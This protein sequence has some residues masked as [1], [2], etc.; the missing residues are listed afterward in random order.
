M[1]SYGLSSVISQGNQS[2]ENILSLNR[3]IRDANNELLSKHREKIAETKEDVDQFNTAEGRTL[4]EA[5]LGQ[6]ASKG[7]DI[8]AVPKVLKALP[9]VASRTMNLTDKYVIGGLNTAV[10]GV[11]RQV[12]RLFGDTAMGESNLGDFLKTDEELSRSGDLGAILRLRNAG[13]TGQAL[14]DLGDFL[15]SSVSVGKTVGEKA[16]SIGKLG[17]ASTGLTVGLGLMDTID[18]I[19]SGKI[20]GKNSAERVSNVAGIVS[21]GLEA[22]GT[23]LDLTGVGAPVGVALNLLGGA[24]GLVG[25]GEDIAGERQEQKQAQQKLMNLQTT[26]PTLEKLQAVQDIASTGAEVK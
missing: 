5:V 23:G 18:D 1:E 6:V 17:L 9:D 26:Q 10:E 22:V 3:Q 11:S 4:G 19:N 24:V 20:D 21:G 2:N 7:K 8:Q 25:A 16:G 12:P 14:G 15:K 13:T